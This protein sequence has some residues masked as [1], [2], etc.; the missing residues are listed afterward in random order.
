MGAAVG[1]AEELEA[2]APLRWRAFAIYPECGAP[3]EEIVIDMVHTCVCVHVCKCVVQGTGVSGLCA[4]C[5]HICWGP[6]GT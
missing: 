5:A 4:G 6:M 3:C 1:E 2:R